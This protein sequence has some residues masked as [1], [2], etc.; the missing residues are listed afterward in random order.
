MFRDFSNT[1]RE[2]LKQYVDDTT[3]SGILETL[4]DGFTDS[5]SVFSSWFNKINISDYINNVSAYH[6]K[7]I[8]MYNYSKDQIDTIFNNV[9]ETDS[10]YKGY[11]SKQVENVTNI[12][13]MIDALADCIDPNAG[14]LEGHY[15]NVRRASENLSNS[16]TAV[17]EDVEES[18][19]GVSAQGAQMS[20]DP[21]NLSTGNFVYDHE[22]LSIG[23]EIPLS[24]HRYYNSKDNRIGSL[25]RCFLHNYDIAI[26][27]STNGEVGVRLSDGQFHHFEKTTEGK[28]IGKT[29]A[30]EDL[31]KTE[32]GFCLIT[33]GKE[34]K[35]F[36]LDGKLLRQENWFGR[37]TTFSYNETGLL[38]EA[39]TDTNSKLIYSYDEN[40]MLTSVSD[41]TGRCV[42]LSY[43]NGNLVKAVMATGAVYSYAYGANGR[44]T[45]VVNAREVVAV[46]NVYDNKYRVTNQV[47]PD[48]GS[49]SFEY[50]DENRQ[51]IMTERNG[52]KTIH[53][54]DDKYR[55]IETIYSDGTKERYIY[56]EKNQCISMTDR[57]GH[58]TR[59]AY[60]NRGNVTQ[61]VDALKK[62]TNIL[63]DAYNNI[64]SISI[65]GKVR[66][67]NHYD[68]KGRLM[69]TENHDGGNVWITYDEQAHPVELLQA[70][71]S[72]ISLA[73][74]ANGNVKAITDAFGVETTYEYDELNRVTKT[75]DGNGNDASYEYDKASRISRVINPD[76]K[77]RCYEYNPSGRVTKVVDFDGY[78][79]SI[80][81]NEVGKVASTTDKENNTTTYTYD[82]M[83][84]LVSKTMPN[85]ALLSNTYDINNRLSEVKLPLGGSIS[86][87]YDAVGNK[88][89]ETDAEGNKTAFVYD[90]ANQLVERIEADGTKTEFKYDREGNLITVIDAMGYETS[91]TYD[92][93][94]RRTSMTDAEGNT[95]SVFY[96]NMG[97]VERVCYAN[98]SQTVYTYETGGR[99]QSVENPD[100]SK[101]TYTYDANGNMLTRT[102]GV[103]D[104]ISFEYDKLNRIVGIINQLGGKRSFSYDIIGNITQIVDE[105]GNQT[106]YE[107]SPNGNL[108]KVT[109][110]LGNET[111]YEYDVMGNLTK[112][113]CTGTSGEEAQHTSFDW[114]LEGHVTSVTDPLGAIESYTYDKNGN[115][116]SKTDKDGYLTQFTYGSSGKLEE[117]LYADGQSVALSYDAL[118]RLKEVKDMLGTTSITMDKM[119]RALSVTDSYG[120]TTGYEWGAMGE[121]TAVIYPD[122]KRA[123]YEYNQAMQLVA[124]HTGSD[125]IR[126]AYDEIGRISKKM[127]PNGVDTTYHYSAFGRVDEIRHEG[128]NVSESYKYEF[129]V[130]GNKIS[131]EKNRA[132]VEADNGKFTYVYDE[133]SRL[134]EV[135][136]NDELLRKYT[137]DAF[138][139]RTQRYDYSTGTE[140]VTNYVYN[141]NNQLLSETDTFVSKEYSY[142]GRGNLLNVKSNDEVLKAFTFDATN[143]MTASMGIV[144]GIQKN[145]TYAYNGLGHRME[146]NIYTG[147]LPE[148]PEKKIQY[149]IDMTRQYYNLLQ[150]NSGE[151]NAQTYY[152]D[153]NVAGMESYGEERFYLQDDL[154]SPMQLLNADGMSCEIFAYDEFGLGLVDQ[155]RTSQMFGFTGYQMDEVGGLYFAQARRYDAQNGRFVSEDKVRG[156]IIVPYT[157]NHYVYCW[158]DPEDYEDNDGNLPTVVVG[159]L[160][161]A[162]V[163]FVG[164]IVADVAAGREVDFKKAGLTAVG[165]AVAG[166]L[167]GTGAGA[168][169][170][171]KVAASTVVTGAAVGAVSSGG[172]EV[173]AQIAEDKIAGEPVS[174]NWNKVS[175]ETIKGG[176]TGG[177]AATGLGTP[178]IAATYAG[179]DMGGDVIEQTTIKNS[180]NYSLS[181]TVSKGIW[182][183]GT[184]FFAGFADDCMKLMKD[185]PDLKGMDYIKGRNGAIAT[186]ED[187]LTRAKKPE[188]IAELNRKLAIAKNNRNKEW[189]RYLG[190]EVMQSG[191]DV[192][193]DELFM[194]EI[195]KETADIFSGRTCNCGTE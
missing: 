138:G 15:G 125:T 80:T 110:A 38:T 134:S 183:F 74:D 10:T 6:T 128:A 111:F 137:Y 184:T 45:E 48:G 24:F 27:E 63:Y 108:L 11:L 118:R 136:H 124:L 35:F 49:M 109:D 68:S 160:I 188:R 82:K 37:G 25:G 143:R 99:L 153:G 65:N 146:Q 116:V 179:V 26:E 142:D 16:M 46:I 77:D 181:E 130:Y 72:K 122:G 135:H 76:G 104:S 121:K 44:I 28:Y 176:V 13:T 71:G 95:T 141:I 103:G 21:V 41:H 140:N 145:A 34:R 17:S 123:E 30:V 79:T 73:Y 91:Y 61:V 102:N 50:D 105:K 161:G 185:K 70:D 119:G 22:D 31:E 149:T 187:Q 175:L 172:M 3:P 171:M 96:N 192:V 147:I 180:E 78:P 57:N 189:F 159:A 33:P 156:V 64:I 144:D 43:E 86:Y 36:D 150:A 66:I 177:F 83:W 54:H 182:S 106:N 42:E 174:I 164:S 12:V 162:G 163:G 173:V 191:K 133:L 5:M 2:E 88:I 152:W 195:E 178:L 23:G 167:I 75:V 170:G 129:D 101:E 69:G 39:V 55:N 67:K 93:S 47:F 18:M 113:I 81:Y 56:N 190:N 168:A 8:D 85:G 107:Y 115:M 53:V 59:M 100:G 154:G 90:A 151:E 9:L 157:M 158:N 97:N 131:T 84:N 94:G 117:V 92:D 166:A 52:V 155:T 60:D 194:N 98:G 186:I 120:K 1:A 112:T 32:N 169:A 14:N 127:L 58:T 29:I 139:N 4:A 20:A 148:N 19:L 51:V 7:I 87:E 40:N 62:R 165:G 132:G 114:D 193:Y 89:S 126:Y